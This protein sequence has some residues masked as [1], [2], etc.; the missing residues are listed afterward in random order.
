MHFAQVP[1]TI[2]RSSEVRAG[3]EQLYRSKK[4]LFPMLVFAHHELPLVAASYL[5]T[6]R[7]NPQ[8]TFE[9]YPVAG[10]TEAQTAVQAEARMRLLGTPREWKE[11]RKQLNA[12]P[13][14]NSNKLDRRELSR[15]FKHLDRTGTPSLDS[16]GSVWEKLLEN[17]EPLIVGVSANNALSE[18]T[19]PTMAYKFLLA[20]VSAV[21][22]SPKH[23]RET[24]LEF[25]RDWNNLERASTELNTI[26][27]RSSLPAKSS[28]SVMT[29]SRGID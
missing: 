5:L 24:M 17:G 4:W 15:Y 8:E 10:L 23:S 1:G 7:F 11:F 25:R 6:G 20:R 9:K 13:E 29:W 2:Q 14:E 3:T 12:L 19:T 27:A 26:S 28:S 18:G 16:D 21:L 22:R